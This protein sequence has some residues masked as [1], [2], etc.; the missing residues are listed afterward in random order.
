MAGLEQNNLGL[1]SW[2]PKW[3]CREIDRSLDYSAWASGETL[4][5]DIGD[6][7][8]EGILQVTVS[9]LA[10]IDRVEGFK[11][12]EYG[13]ATNSNIGHEIRRIA[14]W[15]NLQGLFEKDSKDLLAFCRTICADQFAEAY[16]H[17]E[18]R[19]PE[20]GGVLASFALSPRA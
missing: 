12:P 1:P 14:S 20:P 11:L 13:S 2:V 17:K 6:Q 18:K 10:I 4:T 7:G 9:L 3:L 5:A 15:I 8:Y 19:P 16:Y